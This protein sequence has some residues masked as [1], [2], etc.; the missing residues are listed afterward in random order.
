MGFFVEKYFS[1][2]TSKKHLTNEN[3]YVI[4][5][6]EISNV[7]VGYA[8]RDCEPP[9]LNKARM[10]VAEDESCGENTMSKNWQDAEVCPVF[11]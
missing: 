8:E 9:T 3:Y 11:G 4:I 6:K 1:T 5:K 2:K 7:S 10:G